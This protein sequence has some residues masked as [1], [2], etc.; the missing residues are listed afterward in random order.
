MPRMPVGDMRMVLKNNAKSYLQQDLPNHAFDCFIFPTRMQPKPAEATKGP[1]TPPTAQKHKVLIAGAKKQLV[2][3]FQQAAKNAGLVADCIAPGLIGPVNVFELAMPEI[4]G[5]DVV[6]LVDLGF[7]NSSVSIVAEGE[8][9]LSRTVAIGGDR[10]TSGLAESMNISYAEAEGIKVGMANEVQAALEALLSPLGR[11]LRASIDFFEHQQDRP[12][13]AVYVTGGSARSE[14]IVQALQNEM[15][16]E[17][18]PWNPTTF[19]R[20]ALPPQQTAEVEQVSP[21]LAVA[22]GTAL[23]AF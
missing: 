12:V 2:T 17:C 18:K 4:F 19:L 5:R 11:E 13:G 6:A 15:M 20:L 7:K 22:I 10:L 3:D 9:M 23:A 16:I 1:A 21:Q 14:F 8:L